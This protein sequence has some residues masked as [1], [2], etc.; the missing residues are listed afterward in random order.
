MINPSINYDVCII[1]AGWAG[2]NAALKAAKSG[3]K[4]CL[5]EEG[6]IGGTCLNR[7]CIPTKALVRYSKQ[8]LAF[9]EIQKKKNEVVLRLLD[10]MLYHLKISAI[11]FQ[12][13]R[14]VIAPDG[15]VSVDGMPLETKF[16]LIAAGSVP[17]EL[18][19]LKLDHNK[20]ISSDDVLELDKMPRSILIVGA[21]AIGCEFAGIFNKC[22][23]QVTIVEI[24]SQ[25]LPGFDTHVSKKLQQSF[26]KD[27]IKVLL[28]KSAKDITL[29]DYDK[30][31]L[32]VGRRAALEDTFD[33]GC[34]LNMDKKG[35]IQVDD[36]LKTSAPH[37]FAAGDCI[38]GMMLA[39]VASYEGELAIHNMFSEPKK[40]DYSCVP[41]SVFTT[42]EVAFIGASEGAAKTV[43]TAHSVQTTHYLSVGMAHILEETD[44]FVKVIVDEKDRLILGAG[45]IGPQATELIN[46][47]SV[48]MK[49]KI[50]IQGLKDTILS[51][52]SLSE[53]LGEVAKA[54]D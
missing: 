4:V 3:K 27:G 23:A 51:H 45:I 37:I 1:G 25:L 7:G 49:N 42:P 36:L 38:G 17:A 15:R 28:G 12:Q 47:F 31:F 14:A 40:K 53:I 32:C 30:V 6:D 41:S 39:H 13:G 21:G 22:G 9:N 46:V 34:N 24:K 18:P 44:G 43:G 26:Q 50:P 19:D 10:G 52:P 20:M 48:L 2:F 33:K 35:Y 16:I 54:F 5:I 8:G 11:D 29:G